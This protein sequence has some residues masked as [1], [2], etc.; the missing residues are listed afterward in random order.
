MFEKGQIVTVEIVDMSDKG[1]GIGKADGFT[2]F[3]S[4][5]LPGDRAEVELT[6]VKKRFAM[7]RIVELTRP[8]PSRIESPCPYSAEC[9]G[10]D[11]LEFD[12]SAQ[13]ELKRSQV[14][15]R[16]ERLGGI[17][18]P[19]LSETMGMEE[20]WR[21]R[22]KAV[23]KVDKDGSIGFAKRGSRDIVDCSDC[24]LQMPPVGAAISALRDFMNT[25]KLKQNEKIK[26][27]TVRTAFGTG[28]VMVILET[29]SDQRGMLSEIET[30]AQLLDD[31]VYESGY[32]LESIYID[33]G[34]KRPE[35]IAGKPTIDEEIGG[36]KF[37]IS[38][39]SFYQVNPIMME[40]LYDKV[41]K[42]A[43]LK[44]G[45][46][47]LDLYCGAGTIGLWMIKKVMSTGAFALGIETEPQ[48]ILDANRNAVINGVVGA[49]YILGKSEEVMPGLLDG[50]ERYDPDL[51]ERAKK[52]DVAIVDP[53]RAGC[54]PELLDALI[55]VSP[56]RIVYVSCDPATLARDIAILREGGYEFIEGT[57]VDMFPHTCHVETVCLL[58]Q[59]K[60]DTTI[61]VDLDISELEVSSA[62]TKATYEEIKSYVLEKIGLKVSNLYIAQVKRECGIV[63]RINYNLPKTEGNRVPQCPED[64]RK[65][66]KALFTPDMKWRLVEEFGPHC[67]TE[68]DDGRLLF[69]ADYTDMENLVT[70][71]MIF[72]AKAE[73]LEPAEARGI[74]RRNAE[75][76]L[77]IYGGLA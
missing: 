17:S 24:L 48:A 64:K 71:L 14:A 18:E 36:V 62:E 34:G 2:V 69:T 63:E 42:Y 19:A 75:E 53:P 27:A 10:C 26:S 44:G 59:R 39:R 25:G 68:I 56:G 28:E 37:E 57:P 45:E 5:A 58:S 38:P 8:S 72:G 1:Q 50:E 30:L 15:A 13:L 74:I 12:Y 29:E 52:A 43:D 70:W 76:T 65:A 46:T 47:I 7:G 11:Y 35:L 3:A 55:E 67:F 61:E 49:R 40:K 60:P 20:P 54:T 31:A 41:L 4:G 9:G 23:L 16:L 21:Y 22:N 32:S 33:N 6:K 73:V 51:C 77:K 66:I